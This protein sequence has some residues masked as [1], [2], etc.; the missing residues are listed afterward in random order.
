[1]RFRYTGAF[2]LV[3]VCAAPAAAQTREWPERIWISAGGGVQPSVDGFD[4]EFERPLYAETE[5]VTIAYPGKGG[6]VVAVN[7]GV[8]LWKRF[9]AGA[10]V[11]RYSAR[12]D[13]TVHASLPHP[14]F[15]NQ[16]REIEGKASTLRGETAVHLLLGAMLPITNRLRL[17]VTAGPSL[18]TL[19]HTLVTDVEF[20]ETYPYDT[21]E[22]ASATTRRESRRGTGFNAGA[23]VMWMFSR[24]VGAGALV[25]LTRARARLAAGE[26]RTIAVDAGGLQAAAGIRI[27]F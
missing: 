13:A 3:I 12:G 9:T 14:F 11:S 24:Q 1:M 27:V 20:S 16:F 26:G 18:V 10:G 2:L 7:G 21:A 6:T 22:F 25:Q 19:E 4:D 8:R 23:D 15:D 5:R 17:I